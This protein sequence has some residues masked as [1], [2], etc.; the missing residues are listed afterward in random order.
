MP[1]QH[2]RAT[3]DVP[4]CTCLLYFQMCRTSSFERK[5]HADDHP[6]VIQQ[7]W[8]S[9]SDY[10]FVLMKRPPGTPRSGRDF[11]L[12]RSV[13]DLDLTLSEA[14]PGRVLRTTSLQP[15]Y[16][17]A[18]CCGQYKSDDISVCIQAHITSSETGSAALLATHTCVTPIRMRAFAAVAAAI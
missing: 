15:F 18:R 14:C 6:L 11:P 10:S 9:T 17:F 5:L 8:S 7:E 1:D 13:S 4:V 3:N 12:R 2:S 16:A